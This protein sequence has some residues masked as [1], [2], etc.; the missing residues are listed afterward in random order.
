MNAKIELIENLL[1][2]H[3]SHPMTFCSTH[4]ALDKTYYILIDMDRIVDEKVEHTDDNVVENSTFIEVTS[5]TR[6]AS[7]WR[8]SSHDSISD[9]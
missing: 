7:E 2:N 3:G 8:F 4:V 6:A 5:V 9:I 1:S